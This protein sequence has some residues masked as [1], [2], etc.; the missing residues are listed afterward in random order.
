MGEKKVPAKVNE[1]C[2]FCGSTHTETRY[3]R[4]SFPYGTGERSVMLS[5]EVPVTRCM[6]CGGEFSGPQAELARH[7][8]VCRH[9]GVM[10]PRQIRAIR[11]G[12]GMSRREFAELTGV[13]EASLARWERGL[14][15]QNAAMDRLLY[16]LTFPENLQRLRKRITDPP[17][18][19]S[20]G[21]AD[22]DGGRPAKPRLRRFQP[23]Q[24]DWKAASQFTL[25]WSRQSA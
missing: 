22:Q 4:E 21:T 2:A 11:A 7:E 19:E 12:Y 17:A 18:S 24:G 25:T 14:V 8:A 16:L 6:D 23:S 15:I 5:A 10:T 9:L 3:I 13:G 20:G 1:A